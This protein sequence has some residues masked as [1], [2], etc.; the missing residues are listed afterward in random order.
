MKLL[1]ILPMTLA[2]VGAITQINAQEVEEPVFDLSPFT[3]SAAESASYQVNQSNT[4]TIV[5]MAIKDI[6]MDLTVIGSG[7]MEDFGLTNMDDLD[8]LIPALSNTDSPG[9]DGGGGAT[10]YQLRGFSPH[11]SQ[12]EG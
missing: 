1:L 4:G 2:S 5:A 7:L 9:S 6:P 10:R 3:V 11:I 8:E 12:E